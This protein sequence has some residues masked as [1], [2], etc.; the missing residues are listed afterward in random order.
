MSGV[1]GVGSSPPQNTNSFRSSI[2]GSGT[3]ASIDSS[4]ASIVQI[5][6]RVQNAFRDSFQRFSTILSDVQTLK[7]RFQ[8]LDRS[9]D[10][11]YSMAQS[12]SDPS[13]SEGDRSRL[14]NLFQRELREFQQVIRDSRDNGIDISERDGLT[15]ALR[16]A[17][18][19]LRYE[20]KL[21]SV[22]K[23]FSIGSKSSENS[24][25]SLFNQKITTLEDVEKALAVLE[26]SREVIGKDIG[27]I[28]KNF[29][30]LKKAYDLSISGFSASSQLNPSGVSNFDQLALKLSSEIR[31]KTSDFLIGANSPINKDVIDSILRR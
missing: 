11:L 25:G 2:A 29:D 6:G 5:Q 17:D 16:Q 7:D 20:F 14:N 31:G 19:D 23:G 10:K 30:S 3:G 18:I 26:K 15:K 13:L 24:T 1:S 27:E 9:A 4:S 12:A 28:Q 22:M 21:S 8:M